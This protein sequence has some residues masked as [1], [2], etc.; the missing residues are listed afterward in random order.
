MEV[1]D[2]HSIFPGAFIN[3]LIGS[4]GHLLK[5]HMM[6]TLFFQQLLL[7]IYQYLNGMNRIGGTMKRMGKNNPT[8]E[9]NIPL[10]WLWT[11][12]HQCAF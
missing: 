10:L 8:K 12:N 7:I 4:T 5:I 6:G 9:F 11:Y 1:L 2:D 3:K